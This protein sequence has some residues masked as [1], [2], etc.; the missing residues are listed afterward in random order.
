VAHFVGIDGGGTRTTAVVTSE[1]GNVLARVQG[2]AGRVDVREPA[3]GALTLADLTR[4][5]LSEAHTDAPA[6]A[7]CCAL[8]GAGRPYERNALEHALRTHGVADS[9]VVV[10]DAEAALQDAFG[11]GPGILVIAGTGSSSWGRG[12]NGQVERCGGWG[13]LLGD[14]GSGWAI[15][16]AALHAVVQSHDGRKSATKLT[17]SIMQST[18]VEAADGLIAWT[19]AAA[20]AEIAA[21]AQLVLDLAETDASARGIVETAARDL[22]EHIAALHARLGPWRGTVVVALTGGLVEVNRPLRP[23]VEAEIRKRKLAV[24]LL[25]RPVDAAHG[26]AL[27]AQ[28]ATRF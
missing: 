14:E 25:S 26:A 16:S 2:P 7:L 18:G 22:V 24:E 21:L 3:A 4:T 9:I 19:A 1:A 13:H 12:E 17:A 27:I 8:A 10:G 5:A 6:A 15:G 28:R 11:D 23:F 20:K